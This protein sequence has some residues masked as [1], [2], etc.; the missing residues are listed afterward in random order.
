MKSA[1]FV[2]LS[3]RLWPGDSSDCGDCTLIE[4]VCACVSSSSECFFACVGRARVPH[5]IRASL[6]V[7]ILI[8]VD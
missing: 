7:K 4:L 3:R 2:A 5:G 6:H 8:V 1:V